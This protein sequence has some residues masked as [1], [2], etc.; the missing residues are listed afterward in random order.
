MFREEWT[1][2]NSLLFRFVVIAGVVAGYVGM[3]PGVS[4]QNNATKDPQAVALINSCLTASGG[5][6]ALSA[7]QDFVASGTVTFYWDQPTQ[8]PAVLKERGNQFRFDATLGSGTRSWAVNNG[9][10]VLVN[11]DGSRTTFTQ[12]TAYGLTN[13]SWPVLN[14]IGVLS[15]QYAAISY[16]GLVSTDQGQLHQIHIQE[17]YPA[18]IDPMGT[19]GTAQ[20]KDYFIDPNSFVLV[21]TKDSQSSTGNPG[22]GYD[23][24][25]LF[26][27][28]TSVNGLMVPFSVTE[29]MSW[30]SVKW[31]S[32]V[33]R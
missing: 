25:V 14:L 4:A 5:N 27:N 12:Q 18:S 10:G 13:L 32:D 21:E 30:L 9:T 22:P 23:H 31:R 29:F 11:T 19:M 8:A 6:Q 1:M 28:Y 33:L 17:A 3:V 7:V 20:S 26:S 16:V 15:D 24:L 2:G